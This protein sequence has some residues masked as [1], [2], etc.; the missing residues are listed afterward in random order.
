MSMVFPI[1]SIGKEGID[2]ISLIWGVF[3]Q[4]YG[5]LSHRTPGARG[6]QPDG[7]GNIRDSGN[8]RRI[9]LRP[10][11]QAGKMADRY[12]PDAAYRSKPG[13]SDSAHSVS[14]DGVKPALVALVLL[15]I[16]PILLNTVT[17][18]TE[19]PDFMLETAS[20]L[21]MTENR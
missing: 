18:L 9:C 21:W 6:D 11:S 16:P 3:R 20:G 10:V 5:R 2:T 14:G 19:V 8:I 17:G 15:A 12:V 4:P 1:I 7:A 13:D